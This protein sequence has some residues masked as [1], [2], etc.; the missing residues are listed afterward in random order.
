MQSVSLLKLWWHVPVACAYCLMTRC[1]RICLCRNSRARRV[2]WEWYRW[3]GITH[4]LTASRFIQAPGIALSALVITLMGHRLN[5]K[6]YYQDTTFQVHMIVPYTSVERDLI[7]WARFYIYWTV[8][9]LGRCPT[10]KTG[11]TVWIHH[12]ILPQSMSFDWGCSHLTFDAV[13]MV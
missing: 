2:T 3:S 12:F 1:H 5:D 6:G 13:F 10:L 11:L 4:V 7:D 9:D 8:K